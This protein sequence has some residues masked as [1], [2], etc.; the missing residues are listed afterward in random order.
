MDLFKPSSYPSNNEIIED[1]EIISWEKFLKLSGIRSFKQLDIGLQ[2]GILRLKEE[3][4]DKKTVQLIENT[5][6]KEG[7]I[8]PVEGLFPPLVMNKLLKSI[9]RLGYNWM[10][11][12]D[13]FGTERKLEYIDDFV[14]HS[15]MLNKGKNLFTHNHNILITTHWDRHLSLLCSDKKTVEYLVESCSLEGFYC[16]KSTQINWSMQ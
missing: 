13:E 1:C 2:T 12:G 3:Y 7:I 10:W 9:K 16:N 15:D 4:Q 8:E 5:C 11:I 6:I 14:S